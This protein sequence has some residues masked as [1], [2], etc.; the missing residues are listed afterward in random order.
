[1]K[2]GDNMDKNQDEV[3]Q[4]TADQ[5]NKDQGTSMTDE[6]QVYGHDIDKGSSDLL[7]EDDETMKI[8]QEE[9]E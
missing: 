6:D 5:T 1:M 3:D 8:N 7:E 9:E 4:G 2:G